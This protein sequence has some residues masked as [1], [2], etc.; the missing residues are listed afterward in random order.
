VGQPF[1]FNAEERR[2]SNCLSRANGISYKTF[3]TPPAESTSM[4]LPTRTPY[5]RFFNSSCLRPRTARL[6]P[7]RCTVAEEPQPTGWYQQ[8]DDRLQQSYT[9]IRVSELI[10]KQWVITSASLIKDHLYFKRSRN[11]KLD[12]VFCLWS[13]SETVK[14][15]DISDEAAAPFFNHVMTKLWKL[16]TF[17]HSCTSEVAWWI[18]A[19]A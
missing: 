15:E 12:K 14:Y 9:A 16:P 11:G 19:A 3:P 6:S 8:L 2:E 13:C 18:H 5:L 17:W 4:T 10:Y 7:W 1:L